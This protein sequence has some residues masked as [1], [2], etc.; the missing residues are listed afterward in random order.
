MTCTPKPRH[1]LLYSAHSI[2]RAPPPTRPTR[3]TTCKPA[4][5]WLSDDPQYVV[6]RQQ[7]ADHLQSSGLLLWPNRS[8]EKVTQVDR[9]REDS[10]SRNQSPARRLLRTSTGSRV[11]QASMRDIRHLAYTQTLRLRMTT[12][13][14][15]RGRPVVTEIAAEPLSPEPPRMLA[16]RRDT[17]SFPELR[18]RRSARSGRADCHPCRRPVQATARPELTTGRPGNELTHRLR[19]G[20]C[21][22]CLPADPTVRRHALR[23]C[24][25]GSGRDAWTSSG[26]P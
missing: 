5:T 23:Y 21:V 15:C 10:R 19:T 16:P 3:T 20:L 8:I 9:R 2:L 25:S 11:L 7:I 26:S 24:R 6:G 12:P 1:T 4:S 13:I 22:R 14:G 17:E 18:A